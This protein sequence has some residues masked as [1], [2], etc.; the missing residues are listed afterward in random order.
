MNPLLVVG[1]LALTDTY[2]PDIASSATFFCETNP[3]LISA[4]ELIHSRTLLLYDERESN[5]Q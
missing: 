1:R 2:L 4:A 3:I 5:D